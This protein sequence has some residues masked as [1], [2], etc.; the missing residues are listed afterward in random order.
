MA[1]KNEEFFHDKW[2]GH[3]QTESDGL[4]VAKPV[5]L[6]A[7]CAQHQPTEVQ[8]KLRELCPLGPDESPRHIDDVMQF[9]QQ[10]LD[11]DAD[12]FEATAQIPDEVSLYVPEG[13]QTIRPTFG[14]LH[15]GEPDAVE[16]YSQ[17]GWPALKKGGFDKKL[18]GYFISDTGPLHQ[19]VHLWKFDDDADRRNH[20]N[21]LF[22]NDDFMDFAGDL[23][24]LLLS[25]QNQLLNAAPWG[26]HP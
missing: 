17:K 10:L 1:T 2:L 11:F 6:A 15:Q 14:L 13:P 20:W 3:V 8:E 22:A 7:G 25:Q 16:A 24:P 5:L 18:V 26:P 4:V 23:R 9:F 19:I 12:L 21:S